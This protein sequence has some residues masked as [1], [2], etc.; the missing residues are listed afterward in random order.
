MK[1][2]R[3]IRERRKKGKRKRSERKKK[4]GGRAPPCLPT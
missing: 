4:M 1:E 3:T 2:R